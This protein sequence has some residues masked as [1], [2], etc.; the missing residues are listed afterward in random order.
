M[1]TTPTPGTGTVATGPVAHTGNG[2]APTPTSAPTP[3]PPLSLTVDDAKPSIE[4]IQ[5]GLVGLAMGRPGDPPAAAKRDFKDLIDAVGQ[6]RLSSEKFPLKGYGLAFDAACDQRAALDGATADYY[7]VHALLIEASRADGATF[8]YGI[9]PIA[10]LSKWAENA[11]PTTW[12]GLYARWLHD[13][14]VA[15]QVDEGLTR[16]GQRRHRGDRGDVVARELIGDLTPLLVPVGGADAALSRSEYDEFWTAT[17]QLARLRQAA[18]ARGASAWAAGAAVWMKVAAATPAQYRLPDVVG[19]YASLNQSAVLT[20]KSGGG[21]GVA[22]AVA[23]YFID[24]GGIH[25]G[26]PK[27]GEGLAEGYVRWV[28]V[29]GHP[30]GGEFELYRTSVMWHISEID[31]LGSMQKVQNSNIMP[32]LRNLWMGEEFGGQTADASRARIVPEH[33]VRG[34]LLVSAQPGNCGPLLNPKEL[35]GGTPQRF[36]WAPTRDHYKP[37]ARHRP[38]QPAGVRWTLPVWGDAIPDEVRTSRYRARVTPEGVYVIGVCDAYADEVLDAQD[39]RD[40]EIGDP[41]DGHAILNRG[42]WATDLALYHGEIGMSSLYWELSGVMMRVSDHTRQMMVT[43]ERREAAKESRERA[44][45]RAAGQIRVNEMVDSDAVEKAKASVME[46]LTTLRRRGGVDAALSRAL[47]RANMGKGF[48]E[49]A[50]PALYW[51]HG[52]GRIERVGDDPEA[53][54]YRLR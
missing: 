5:I 40:N 29:E 19:D 32:Y 12:A 33:A 53:E 50:D 54:R 49:H 22:M 25:T 36:F 42:K 46:Q 17:E 39:R 11:P 18:H 34:T 16:A 37:D 43:A 30:N 9:D 41:L 7:A 26:I 14:W 1:A 3:R 52:Q 45:A 44:E 47:L 27:T 23:R 35:R 38:E 15:R 6:Y 31:N 51:L 28:P 48:R 20:G 2:K 10:D 13:D 21:K 8:A 4:E 24:V